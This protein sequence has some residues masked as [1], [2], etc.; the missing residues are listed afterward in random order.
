MDVG[1]VCLCVAYM[2]N[3]EGALEATGNGYRVDLPH[4]VGGRLPQE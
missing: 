1:H 4:W 3:L 2:Y